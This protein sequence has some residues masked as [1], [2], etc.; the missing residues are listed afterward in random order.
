MTP[1][2]LALWGLIA[3]GQILWFKTV[4][5]GILLVLLVDSMNVLLLEPILYGGGTLAR[6]W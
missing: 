6:L 2:S 5:V 1:K 4:D 3:I